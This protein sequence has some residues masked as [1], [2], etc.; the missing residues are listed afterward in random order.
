MGGVIAQQLLFEFPQ[1]V[2]KLVL[3]NTFTVL[4]PDNLSGW[5][6]LVGRFV[7]VHT[8]GLPTQ[9]KV[10]AR[11]IFTLA[12]QEELRQMLIT[13]ITQS[14]PHAYRAAMRA[15]ALFDSRK[16]LSEINVPTLIITGDR[17]TTVPPPRQKLLVDGIPG[18]RQVII[19]VAGHAV[20]VEQPEAFNRE[21]M[22]F[23]NE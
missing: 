14:D 3:V 16:R 12:E 2:H 15:L 18:A 19:P 8:V 10:V 22:A 11:R 21:L 9:A 20:I 17:D 4:R 23:L 1:M 13:T 5:A 7:M 6:Y